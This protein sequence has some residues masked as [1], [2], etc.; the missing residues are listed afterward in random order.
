MLGGPVADWGLV[1]AWRCSWMMTVALLTLAALILFSVPSA[2]VAPPAVLDAEAGYSP[3][4][5][6]AAGSLIGTGS[7]W[8]APAVPADSGDCGQHG[9]GAGSSGCCAKVK[10]PL[11]HSGIA[12]ISPMPTPPLEASAAL[13][14]SG[15]LFEGIGTL[16]GLRPPRASA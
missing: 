7:L 12:P 1:R 4:A 9:G 8:A 11:A 16:P 13:L 15:L 5:T 2:A 3:G 14:P 10:C 6:L